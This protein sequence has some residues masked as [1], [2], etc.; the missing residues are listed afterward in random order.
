MLAVNKFLK[1]REDGFDKIM[2]TN[3]LRGCEGESVLIESAH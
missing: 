1:F 3:F 2:G